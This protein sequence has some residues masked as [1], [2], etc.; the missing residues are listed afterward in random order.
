MTHRSSFASLIL[1]AS[2]LTIGTA[3]CNVSHETDFNAQ[4]AIDEWVEMWNS[5]DLDQ[6]D[7]LFLTDAHVSYLSSEREGAIIG[8]DAVREH[9]VGFGFV[10][11]GEPPETTLWMEDVEVTRPG[12][13]AVVTGTWYF[14]RGADATAELQRGP[15]TFVY[16]PTDDGYRIAHAHFADY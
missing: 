7:E 6:V 12:G 4:A 9:H 3:A 2:L 5:F 13:I 11:G 10:S 1:T 16:V 15:V 14:R 8:I